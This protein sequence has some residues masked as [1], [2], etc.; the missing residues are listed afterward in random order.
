MWAGTQNDS[1]FVRC[2]GV[3]RWMQG[4][5][6]FFRKNISKEFYCQTRKVLLKNQWVW[7]DLGNYYG[8]FITQRAGIERRPRYL[9]F[10]GGTICS[11]L[12]PRIFEFK[13][14]LLNRLS[15]QGVKLLTKWTAHNNNYSLQNYIYVY[16]TNSSS[17]A[18]V[19][20]PFSFSL[21]RFF[22]SCIVLQIVRK[23]EWMRNEYQDFFSYQDFEP[24]VC[25]PNG[26]IFSCDNFI[27]WIF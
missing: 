1:F 6:V 25:I 27:M 14:F 10:C 15:N 24:K 8:W 9:D 16:K 4:G 19:L 26:S 23:E 22:S 13:L 3:F 5:G 18:S 11:C 7:N 2:C 12:F 17:L 20:A 21:L